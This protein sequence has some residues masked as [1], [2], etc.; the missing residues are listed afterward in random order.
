MSLSLSMTLANPRPAS[1]AATIPAPFASVNGPTQ[2]PTVPEAAYESWSVQ[3]A[4]QPTITTPVPFTASRQ[5]Y[6]TAGATTTYLDT[7]YVTK[8][9]RQPYPNQGSQSALT[10]ALSD[11]IYSTDTPSGSVTNNSTFTSPTPIA[12]WAT[13]HRRVVGNSIGGDTDPI[14]VEAY[15]RNARGGKQVACVIFTISDGT[16]TI[17]TSAVSTPIVSNRAGDQNPVIVYRMP[18]TDITSLTATTSGVILLT[19][20]AKVY[21]WIG[22]SASIADSS[23]GT[24]GSG[25]DFGPR[26][27]LKNVALAAAPYYVYI[28]SSTGNNAT[29]VG[30]TT[31]AT[32]AALPFLTFAAAWTYLFNNRTVVDGCVIRIN[33][34]ISDSP[35]FNNYKQNVG[36]VTIERDPAVARSGAVLQFGLAGALFRPWISANIVSPVTTSCVRFHDITI[37]RQGTG[38]FQGETANLELIFDDI[39]FDGDSRTGTWNSNSHDY[40]YGVTFTNVATA[41]NPLAQGTQ[42]HRIMRGITADVNFGNIDGWHI[43]GSTI[44]RLGSISP[45]T[46]FTGGIVSFNKFLNNNASGPILGPGTSANY[47]NWALVQNVI[48]FTS[49]TTSAS[50]LVSG[51]S[52]ATGSNSHVVIH[53]NTLVGF[54][55][56]GRSN[57]FYDENGSARTSKL[58]SVRGNIHT[59][60]NTKSDVFMTNGARIG[61]WGY[62]Y[63]V[64]CAYEWSQY[65]D[66]SSAGLGSAFAQAY[67]GVGSSIGTS[68]ATPQMATSYFTNY[69]GTTSG[70]TGGSGSGTYSL[71]VSAPVKGLVVDPVLAYDL[72][73]TARPATL[74]TAGAYVGA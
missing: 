35:S 66:A 68:A 34:T 58:Q 11:Y 57:L 1:A 65:I 63:G 59:E 46:S 53:N 25:R 3:Y 4:A 2:G 36:Y 45:N 50:L 54:F 55:I 72:A 67:P 14:E 32:A 19:V 27:F 38:T 51:D 60:I 48:E 22:A 70:P 73:G 29:A 31:A 16:T 30:S 52:P 69:Q 41:T 20:N 49:A 26:Y 12:N 10:A 43:T 61:N 44:T 5:G 24:A 9:V 33:G 47:S 40:F 62:M 64:G 15:H 28:N 42:Q 37:Q 13:P 74:D 6:D 56:N 7:F 23:A 21:P 39:N 8:A 18:A 17:T 71:N